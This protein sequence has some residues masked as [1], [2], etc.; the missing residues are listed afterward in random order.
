MEEIYIS[1]EKDN[2]GSVKVIQR[3]GGVYER[4]FDHEGA[5]A[6][7]YKICFK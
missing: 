4:S 1:V 2:I 3:N 6:D 7:I 5:M